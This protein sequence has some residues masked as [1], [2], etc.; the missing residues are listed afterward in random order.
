[1]NIHEMICVCD[2]PACVAILENITT[3]P[4][5]LNTMPVMPE[6]I[7][8]AF[9]L[10]SRSPARIPGPFSSFSMGNNSFLSFLKGKRHSS[11]VSFLISQSLTIIVTI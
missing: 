9:S 6:E 7:L 11:S 10:K 5:M 1:M 2:S 4:E 8:F 3:I